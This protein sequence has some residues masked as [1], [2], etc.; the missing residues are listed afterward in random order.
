MTVEEIGRASNDGHER[1]STCSAFVE[2][3]RGTMKLHDLQPAEG[4]RK[5]RTRSGAAS[6]PA[7][8]RRPGAAPRARTLAP[9][10]GLARTSRVAS[11]RWCAGLPHLRGFTNIWR[12]EYTPINLDRLN[13]FEAGS[14]VT[15]E[16]LVAAGMIK[17]A[18]EAGEDPGRR[19]TGPATDR[20]GAQVLGSARR[21][22]WRPAARSKNYPV[23]SRAD[24]SGVLRDAIG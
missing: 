16:T 11:C 1:S 12:V 6:R 20:Q 4:A 15:P 17:S 5:D 8:A 24:R 7:A 23:G 9:A 18:R 2:C 10:A 13:D 22:S 3:E 14:E 19:R 21:R